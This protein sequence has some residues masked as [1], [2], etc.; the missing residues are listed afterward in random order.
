[1]AG[2]KRDGHFRLVDLTPGRSA[3]TLRSKRDPGT[4]VFGIHIKGEVE[5]AKVQPAMLKKTILDQQS[6]VTF[7]HGLNAPRK[8]Q[9]LYVSTAVVNLYCR[10]SAQ[11][12]VDDS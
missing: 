3:K 1:M 7:S 2:R 9:I 6:S 11:A 5:D 4:H 10:Y 12:L 8:M